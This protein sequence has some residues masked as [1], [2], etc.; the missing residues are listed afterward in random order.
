MANV[1]LLNTI[2][3]LPSNIPDMMRNIIVVQELSAF[4][5]IPKGQHLKSEQ[6]YMSAIF[7]AQK[8]NPPPVDPPC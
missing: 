4:V 1:E 2:T 5:V 3:P 7:Q 6:Y 8:A